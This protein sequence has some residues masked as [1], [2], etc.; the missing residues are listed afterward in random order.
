MTKLNTALK[1]ANLGFFIHPLAPNSKIPAAM[2][3]TEATNNLETIEKWWT[4]NP[5]YNIAIATEPSGLAVLDVDTGIGKNGANSLAA[6]KAKYGEEI[7]STLTVQTRS[8]GYHFYFN[9]KT[10][11]IKSTASFIAP[12]IDT[13]AKGGYVVAPGS[14]IDGV[15]YHVVN[16]TEI[17]D[18]PEC[19]EFPAKAKT[20]VQSGSTSI[21]TGG[22]NTYLTSLAG[23]Y[24]N[25]NA[26]ESVISLALN[27]MNKTFDEPLDENEINSIVRSSMNWLPPASTS[28]QIPTFEYLGKFDENAD[29][30]TTDWLV[31]KLIKSTS[32]NMIT[33][34]SGTGKSTFLS[35]LIKACL[36]GDDFLD[37][38]T[39]KVTPVMWF[40][41]DESKSDFE[42]RAR[43]NAIP[44]D[45][46]LF[47][48]ILPPT[49]FCA[50][51]E[52]QVIKYNPKIV[53]LDSW[54]R[55]FNT[56][57]NDNNAIA[58]QLTPLAQLK[59]KYNLA[60]I[61][62]HHSSE[63][64]N[65]AKVLGASAFNGALD[66]LLHMSRVGADRFYSVEKCR[67]SEANGQAIQIV[68]DENNCTI[69]QVAAKVDMI[70][71]T[72]ARGILQKI[73][74]QP[75]RSGSFHRLFSP[76]QRKFIEGA[77]SLL[78][79]KNAVEI[80]ENK[81]YS[82]TLAGRNYLTELTVCLP[83]EAVE[84]VVETAEEKTEAEALPVETAEAVEEKTETEAVEVKTE[85][86]PTF[87]SEYI[88]PT[89]FKLKG[90][91]HE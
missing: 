11:N 59:D 27:E 2:W 1:L 23:K 52:E 83:V 34:T 26:N 50:W 8:G 12:D 67:M 90:K 61:I 74:A 38:A 73:M 47:C 19:I 62:I 17:L 68:I 36:K 13:R 80:G 24:R 46:I 85:M 81:K 16:A 9:D 6:L 10:G 79:I 31:H 48:N 58:K 71:M 57:I 76:K 66:T 41:V 30:V 78:Q 37:R 5:D 4:E 51:L 28:A 89:F 7:F 86:L 64:T 87:D 20:Q 72:V 63:K 43:D 18:W 82:I 44:T 22:R 55:I 70:T 25:L 45:E 56:D 65:G 77:L 60:I 69:K 88:S 21:P 49:N 29:I 91:Q 53:V 75:M 32:L 33:A 3:K 35:L 84:A 54:L 39:K 15:K 42:T 14:I 40:G